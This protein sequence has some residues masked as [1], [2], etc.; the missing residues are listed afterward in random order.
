MNILRNVLLLIS[1]NEYLKSKLPKLRFVNKAVKKFMPGEKLVDAVSAA[2]NLAEIG[3]P[4]VFTKL[5]ENINSLADADSVCEHYLYAIDLI[6]ENNLNIEI[7]V[8]LT[9]LGFDLSDEKTF[10]NFCR[11][12]EHAEKKLNN[13][14]FIDMENS[15][16]TQR[17]IDFYKL[18]KQKHNNIGLC[19]QAYLHD[20]ENVIDSLSAISPQIRLVKGAYKENAEIA[21]A[22][23]RDVDEN[24]LLLSKKLIEPTKHKN[25]RV[26]YATH[27]P[28]LIEKIIAESK[29]H[30]LDPHKLEF[31][32]LYGIRP[33]AQIKLKK[34]G[35]NVRVLI[36]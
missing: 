9:Q 11:I 20:T 3:I 26:I 7:S 2:K 32:M 31:Q 13:S 27:D 21:F 1:E 8:K 4:S 14:V 22:R 28:N 25:V 5:G 35:F 36:A 24:Y 33:S 34:D 16:Y 23:K 6:A 29:G 30:Y 15:A 18:A 10:E 12:A 17:T 19:L